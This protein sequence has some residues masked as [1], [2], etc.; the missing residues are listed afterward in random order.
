MRRKRLRHG[1]GHDEDLA[2]AGTANVLAR[3]FLQRL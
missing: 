3:V 1:T 2:A